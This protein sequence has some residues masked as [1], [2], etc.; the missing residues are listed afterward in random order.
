MNNFVFGKTIKNVRKDR[1]IKLTTTD[2]RIN[3]LVSEH[4]YHT[5]KYFRKFIRPRNEKK[6]LKWITLYI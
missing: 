5:T 4:T 1:N 6:P 3:Q 2:K